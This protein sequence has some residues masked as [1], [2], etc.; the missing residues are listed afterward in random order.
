MEYQKAFIDG[1]YMDLPVLEPIH[2]T[3]FDRLKTYG[4]LMD[5]P[6]NYTKEDIEIALAD[7]NE[8]GWLEKLQNGV[9]Q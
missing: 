9:K 7:L 4:Y 2:L 6:E 5:L 1:K 8:I 3:I